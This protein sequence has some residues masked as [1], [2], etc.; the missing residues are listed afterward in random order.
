MS[1]T[2][3]ASAKEA[4]EEILRSSTLSETA[5]AEV[6]W[7]IIIVGAGTAGIPC[8]LE[9]AKR[10]MK[11]I[12]VVEKANAI[13]GTLHWTVG[14]L[15]GGGTQ[16]Q[17]ARGIQDSPE[18]HYE[19]VMQISHQTADPV[20]TRLATREAP[21]TIDWLAS[22]GFPFDKDVPKIIYGHVPYKTART[23]YANVQRGGVVMLSLM[24]PLWD[25]YVAKGVITPLLNH[26]LVD[27]LL[28][29]KRA[30]GITVAKHGDT[31]QLITVRG[32][33]IV[34]ATGGYAAN[35]ALFQQKHPTAPRLLST[36]SP[37][38]MGEGIMAAERIGAQF[39]NA[40]KHNISLGGIEIVP[41]SGRVDYWDAWAIVFTSKYRTTREFYV[42]ERGERFMNEDEPN[43]DVR[44]R[45]VMQQPNW[46]FW[47][48]FDERALRESYA[49]NEPLVRGWSDAAALRAH[50]A[51]CTASPSGG[52]Y[53]YT[54]PT[55]KELAVKCSLPPDALERSAAQFNAGREG[56]A[57]AFGRMRFPAPC[58]TPPYY[59]LC[60]QGCSLISFGGL[61]VNEHLQVLDVHNKPIEGLYAAGEILGAAATSG[62]A[63]CGGMLITPALSFGRLL[64]QTLGVP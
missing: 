62:H 39:R 43:A 24:L 41:N 25:E 17:Q 47:I 8:A 13:G 2:A 4:S 40:D 9:A 15:S 57:D 49:A 55:L 7:D 60:I 50:A 23:H 1:E 45:A 37:T 61:A 34:L 46:R 19:E 33:N 53:C 44:E 54:A 28:D 64:G 18:R 14:H 22:L 30:V 32:A 31:E 6:L 38:S 56:V 58:S 52:M 5:L 10:G 59:A 51:R 16:R 12:L 63:F 35:P 48:V 26:T 27:I 29:K 20:L 36:A 3:E 11:R 42:N 21:K